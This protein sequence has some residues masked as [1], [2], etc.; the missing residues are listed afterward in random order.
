LVDRIK[1]SEAN[2]AA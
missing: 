1:A 2:L